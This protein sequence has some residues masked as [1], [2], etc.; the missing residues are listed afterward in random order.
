VKPGDRIK[1]KP[2]RMRALLAVDG[3]YAALIHLGGTL[4]AYAYLVIGRVE[5]EGDVSWVTQLV[6]H[7]EYHNKKVA[8]RLL[9]AAW[10]LSD[11]FAWGLATANPYAV[12]ALESATRRSCAPAVTLRHLEQLRQFTGERINYFKDVQFY[13]DEL[14]SIVDTRFFV[15]HS[16]IAEKME[17]LRMNEKTWPLGFLRDGME[18]FAVTFRSQPQR[19]FTVEDL[20]RL[21]ADQDG[22]VKEAYARML[23]NTAHKWMKATSLEVDRIIELLGIA[24][25]ARVLDAGCGVGRHAIE[26]AKRGYQVVG[27]DFVPSLIQ[28]AAQAAQEAGVADRAKFFVGDCRNLDLREQ[29]DGAICLYDVVGSF[30]HDP[31]NKAILQGVANHIKHG[32]RLLMSVL[33]RGLVEAQAIHRGAIGD[34]LDALLRLQPS[35]TMQKTGEIFNPQYYFYDST[36][37]VV[38]RKEQFTLDDN[39]P[40]E[41]I[42]RDRRYDADE[43]QS[44]CRSV[45]IEPLWTRHVRMG[46]WDDNLAA[47]DPNAKEVLL[48]GQ[49]R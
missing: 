16:T 7:T 35:N 17:R 15:S 37:G 23:L 8:T 5:G 41:L 36:S 20:D 47:H 40:C 38:Y 10:G 21:L 12:R 22:I 43:L 13:V 2:K 18:W 30:P 14:Q 6:V 32:R 39:I 25:G 3:A 26:L 1:M 33:N 4:V 19:R 49:A 46:Q 42:V 9:H 27:V 34:N 48:L 11:R 24:P 31:D 28:R 44:L 29:F 45:G